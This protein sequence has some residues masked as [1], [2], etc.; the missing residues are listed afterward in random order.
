MISALIFQLRVFFFFPCIISS[1]FPPCVCFVHFFLIRSFSQITSDL[2]K[3]L[4]L[5]NRTNWEIHAHC[6]GLWTVNC[7]IHCSGI[8]W[9]VL[10][11]KP[12]SSTVPPP[13]PPLAKLHCQ[14][15]TLPV[16]CLEAK[17]LTLC[18]GNQSGEQ[19]KCLKTQYVN[20]P[21]PLGWEGPLEVEMATHYTILAR[22]SHGQRRLA[23][24][25]PWGQTQLS[26]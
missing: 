10:F 5:K 15:K 19:Y 11:G 16:S 20:F 4:H 9:T 12:D 8:C 21:F 13:T 24:Y 7:D 26:D 6:W 18:L 2:L 14:E 22:E 1:C 23:G 3:G 17:N 25:H